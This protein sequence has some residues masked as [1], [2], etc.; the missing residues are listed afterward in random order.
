MGRATPSVRAKLAEVMGSIERELLPMLSEERR[1]AYERVA[2]AWVDEYSAL[3]S[4]SNPHLLAALLLISILDLQ[5][6]V[7]HLTEVQQMLIGEPLV[8]VVLKVRKKGVVI[9]PKALRQAA[10][11]EEGEV[12]AEAGPGFVVL[13]SL[14]PRE[15]DVDPGLVEQLLREEVEA[16][17]E[18]LRELLRLRGGHERGD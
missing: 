11:I 6:Q 15:V 10:G 16:E 2:R 17:G 8:K 4:Y 18:K 12:L 3:A 14:K 7:N 9:L 13:R 1:K 5:A